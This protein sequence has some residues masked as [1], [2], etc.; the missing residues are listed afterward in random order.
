MCCFVCVCLCLCVCVCVCVCMCARGRAFGRLRAHVCAC[1]GRHAPDGEHH[2]AEELAVEPVV[3]VELARVN[4]GVKPGPVHHQVHDSIP[5]MH[6]GKYKCRQH[7]ACTCLGLN[8]LCVWLCGC[9]GVWMCGC[10][11]VCMN[12]RVRVVYGQPHAHGRWQSLLHGG[13]FGE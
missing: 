5:A 13:T 12:I 10:V 3:T 11:G 4:R 9:V 7:G 1:L 6:W 2:G 8:S